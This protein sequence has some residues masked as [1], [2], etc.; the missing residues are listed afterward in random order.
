MCHIICL[1]W[2]TRP[3]E[4][5]VVQPR[6]KLKII[7][8][9]AKFNL[10]R[11]PSLRNAVKLI[12]FFNLK[13]LIRRYGTRTEIRMNWYRYCQPVLRPENESCIQT[14]IKIKIRAKKHLW[15][16]FFNFVQIT[17]RN[18]RHKVFGPRRFPSRPRTMVIIY[19]WIWKRSVII[20]VVILFS[21]I[22]YRF[23]Y[24]N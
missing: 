23:I 18:F 6:N 11:G 16:L 12:F 22:Q 17:S 1:N 15:I 24:I 13:C 21:I 2:R 14:I 9:I 10:L 19:E 8:V 4:G 7:I 5:F 20:T 3:A